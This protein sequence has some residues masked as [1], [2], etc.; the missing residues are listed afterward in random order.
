M[1]RTFSVLLV[2]LGFTAPPSARACSFFDLGPFEV[3]P[4]VDQGTAPRPARVAELRV[5]RGFCHDIGTLALELHGKDVASYGYRLTVVAGEAPPG[6]RLKTE[7][8]RATDGVVSAVWVDSD[9]ALRRAFYFSLAITVVDRAGRESHAEVIDLTV[10]AYRRRAYR[11]PARATSPL[12]WIGGFCAIFAFG[13]AIGW[14]RRPR[15][16]D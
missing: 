7:P 16:S 12:L 15:L 6:L 14:L 4:G 3:D 11:S 10:G 13:V 1:I 8:Y 5:S 9:D 2:F